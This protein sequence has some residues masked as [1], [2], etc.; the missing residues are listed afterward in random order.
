MR[1]S[2]SWQLHYTPR[3]RQTPSQRRPW[4]VMM[5][6]TGSLQCSHRGLGQVGCLYAEDKLKLI[7]LL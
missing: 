2:A 5:L 3:V 6:G 7:S 4:G 1:F